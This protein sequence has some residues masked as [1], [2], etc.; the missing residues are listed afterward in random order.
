MDLL[1]KIALLIL[2][3]VIRFWSFIRDFYFG[4]TK[5]ANFLEPVALLFVRF[6][7]AYV[8]FRSG[9][10]KWTGFLS[11]N[12]D[13]Y[14]LFLYEFFCPLPPR[15]GALVLCEHVFEDGVIV[16][17][18]YAPTT[19][20]II[21]R[22]ANMAGIMEIVLPILIML[23]LFSRFAAFGLLA[24]TLFIE[25]FVFPDSATWW[26]SHIWWAATLFIIVARGPGFL[27]I[28]RWVGL[29]RSPT[30]TK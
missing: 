10:T 17:G 8:F 7:P 16:D 18:I 23:G 6:A 4:L 29:E 26:G 13:K 27:S 11:F 19:Q 14:G 22:F 15:D 24:M 9:L 2:R 28:D 30:H 1:L 25:F 12:S 5:R 3:L 20:W 21:E